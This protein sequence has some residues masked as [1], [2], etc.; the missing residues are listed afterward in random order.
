MWRHRIQENPSAAG[1]PPRTSLGSLQRSRKPPSW[2]GGAGCPSPRTPSPALGPFCVSPL[3]P[4]HSKISS[5]AVGSEYVLT[6]KNVT[7][8]HSKLLLDNS[9]SFTS[10]KTEDFCQKWQVKTNFSTRPQAPRNQ[11]IVDCLEI[12]DVGCNLRQFDGLTW[13]TLTLICHDRATP[14]LTGNRPLEFGADSDHDADPDILKREFLR[15]RELY[16]RAIIKNGGGI[17]CLEGNLRYSR[18]LPV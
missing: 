11:G 7:F 13:P 8:F 2:W 14:L 6:S 16:I 4:M 15:L 10:S 17:C 1:A 3:L 18:M 12:T 5:D 9:S